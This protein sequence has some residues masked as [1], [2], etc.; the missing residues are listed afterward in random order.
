MSRWLFWITAV[1]LLAVV[2]HLSYVLFVPGF[3]M[4]S[5]V[6]DIRR[7]AGGDG[8]VVLSREDGVRL[9]GPD[10]RWLVHALCIYDLAQGPVMITAA[11]PKS[12]WSM[13]IFSMRGDN[14]YSIN[15]RQADVDR[16]S[17]LLKPAASQLV[18]DDEQE[19]DVPEGDT[20]AVEAPQ[21]NGLVVMRAL[22]AEPAQY[23]RIAKVLSGSSCRSV[24]G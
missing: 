22:A 17:V 7:L 24:R 13:S 20:V 12:Y 16:L 19:I 15:D 11:I 10:G 2:V 9:M 21:P 1:L 23:G 14:F 8:L 4:R 5:K 18:G 6:D 3:E